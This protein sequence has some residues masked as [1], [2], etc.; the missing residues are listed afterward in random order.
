MGP[1]EVAGWLLCLGAF[2]VTPSKTQMFFNKV[3]GLDLM[4]PSCLAF[5]DFERRRPGQLFQHFL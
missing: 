4:I 3:A 1:G 5:G 2:S